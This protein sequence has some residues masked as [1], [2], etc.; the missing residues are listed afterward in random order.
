MWVVAHRGGGDLFPENSLTAF[1]AV[2]RL[3]VDFIE[4]DV[5]LSADGHLMVVHDRSLER[6]ANIH[7]NVD[8]LTRDQLAC[9]DVG[10]GAGVPALEEVLSATGVPLRVELK[11]PATLQALVALLRQHP[12][13]RDGMTPTSFDHRLMRELNHAVPGLVTGALLSGLPVHP[14]AVAREAGC[15]F[16]SLQHRLLD[17]AYIDLCHQEGI[18]VNAWTPNRLEEIRPL[19][20]MGIDGITS[21]R[22]DLVLQAR[23]L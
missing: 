9:L 2:G 7:A 3:G 5:H 16:M 6:T 20:Q 18:L 13:W 21:D 23:A 1:K 11:S 10:D 14:G 12:T 22:P 15:R 4:C 8:E 19:V 17:A